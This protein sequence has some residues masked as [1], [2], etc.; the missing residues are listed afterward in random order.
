MV[1]AQVMRLVAQ[2]FLYPFLR[3]HV[4]SVPGKALFLDDHILF[5]FIFQFL[6]F[7]S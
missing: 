4:L 5:P 7:Q 1:Q 2:V 6:L 3:L